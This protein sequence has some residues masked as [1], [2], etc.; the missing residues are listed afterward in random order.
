VLSATTLADSCYYQMFS[1]CTRLNNITCLATN[2]SATD[3]TKNWLNGVASTGT[4]NKAQGMCDWI[5]GVNGIPERWNVSPD[6]CG[7]DEPEY[8]GPFTIKSLSDSNRIKITAPE[9]N[10]LPLSYNKNNS[11]TWVPFTST[12]SGY[13]IDLNNG[14]TLQLK[15]TG[16]TTSSN[17]ITASGNFEVYGNVASLTN[18]Q[19]NVSGFTYLF[20]EAKTLVS[21]KNLKLSKT[22]APDCYHFMFLRCS[23]LTSAPELPASTLASR[24]Y[25]SMFAYCKG[26]KTPP[27]LSA[28]TLAERCYM[29]MFNECTGLT[30]A[31]DL[32]AKTLTTGCYQQMFYRCSGITSAPVLPATTLVSNCYNTM[33]QGCTSLKYI[34]AMFTTE[35]NST[36]TYDWVNGVPTTSDGVFVKNSAAQWDVRGVNGIPNNWT[37]Q[38]APS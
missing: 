16:S 34:K 27:A 37:V 3:C 12:T 21:A 24:C 31:P 14:D 11:G 10:E 5:R 22:L 17:T 13:Y 32:P 7:G 6:D 19:T 26:L 35:P 2:I 30:S 38:R 9:G 8:D 1:Y 15:G 20:N 25:A 36:Y 18:G 29:S 4:F 33:F 23:G 28:E